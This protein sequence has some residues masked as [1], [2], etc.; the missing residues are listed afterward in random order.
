M[1]EPLF[2]HQLRP[3]DDDPLITY[4]TS[5]TRYLNGDDH[6]TLRVLA[7]QAIVDAGIPVRTDVDFTYEGHWFRARTYQSALHVEPVHI[8]R[9]GAPSVYALPVRAA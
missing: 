9:P 1:P 5:L 7:W 2:R 8:D 4:P 6:E 3:S